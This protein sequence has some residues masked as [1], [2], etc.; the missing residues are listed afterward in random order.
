[1]AVVVFDV[2]RE[3]S[4]N[5]VG[6]TCKVANYKATGGKERR[7]HVDEVAILVL[8]VEGIGQ[9]YWRSWVRRAKRHVG[10]LFLLPLALLMKPASH[11]SV[12]STPEI[13]RMECGTGP[14]RWVGVLVGREPEVWPLLDVSSIDVCGGGRK[15]EPRASEGCRALLRRRVAVAERVRSSQM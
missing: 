13:V 2:W 8:F 12:L 1:M 10:N 11:W 9:G 7:I 6:V 14:G 5:N 15:V 4:P 3:R